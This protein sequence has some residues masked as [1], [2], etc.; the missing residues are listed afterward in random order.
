MNVRGF[1]HVAVNVDDV[2]AA[3][4]FYTNV[5]GLSVRDDRPGDRGRD[6][7]WLDAGPQQLHLR[8]SNVPPELGQH[9]ALQ[10]D[11]LDSVVRELRAQ[12]LDITD[13]SPIGTGR[14]SF[15]VDP[16]G[17]RIELH[18]PAAS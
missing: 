1:H 10:V 3:V 15:V 11:D 9:F 2:P 7:A 16:A 12:G 8:Q 17:N 18:Q 4:D 5:L 14:Q 13:P 6:G